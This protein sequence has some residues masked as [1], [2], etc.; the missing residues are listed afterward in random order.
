MIRKSLTLLALALVAAAVAAPLAQ[1][2]TP[3]KVDPLAVGLLAAYGVTP[4]EVT[5]WTAGGC[6]HQAKASSCYTMLDRTSVATASPKVDPLAVGLLA[7]YG[8]SPSEVTSWTAGPC[9]HQ[10]KDSSCYSM[11]DPT[12]AA[13]A[14]T[15]IARSIGFQWGDAAIGAGATL[16]IVLLLGG[17]GAGLLLSRQNRRRQIARA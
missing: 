15:Q 5:S 12:S 11:L 3:P 1:A 13:A 17:A 10:V 6:S 4:S 9:S 8:L 16:G 7:G 14:S 2:T